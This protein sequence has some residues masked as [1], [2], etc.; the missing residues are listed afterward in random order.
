MFIKTIEKVENILLFIAAASIFSMM[1]LVSIDVVFRYVLNSPLEIQ[2]ELT[3]YYLM[4]MSIVLAMPWGAREGAYIKITLI[5]TVISEPIRRGLIVI[6]C[7]IV[8]AVFLLVS[9]KSLHFTIE[10]WINQEYIFGVI[11][12]PVWLARVWIPIGTFVLSIRMIANVYRYAVLK[13]KL[14]GD[15]HETAH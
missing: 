7:L 12:W 3:T 4:V 13:E 6:N 5:K 1:V 11:E 8:A 9:W 10:S 14:D 2:F 15:N